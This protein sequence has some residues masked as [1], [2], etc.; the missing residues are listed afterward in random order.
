LAL[1]AYL[2][3]TQALLQNP[4]APSSLYDPAQLTT[5]I[6]TA[7]TW[8]AGESQSIKV[9]GTLAITSGNRGPYAFSSISLAGATGVQGVLNVRMARLTVTGGQAPLSPRSWPWF[10]EYNFS[11]GLAAAQPIEW[12][13]YGEGEN[14]TLYFSPPPNANFTANLDCVCVPNAL[15]VD[16]DPEAIPA[17][18][19]VAVPYFAAYLALLAAQ[20][21]AR[22]QD[23]Q[24]MLQLYELF[25]DRARKFA[26][27]DVVPQQY[28]Q[29]P[30]QPQAQSQSDRAA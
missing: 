23:A 19:T 22:V 11:P 14:G 26:T 28:P 9:I 25:T 18:W 17:L 20:T 6:N 16:A 1:T 2:T 21:G 5:S 8:V 15:A 13:Q 27:P 10:Q 7:R 3:A 30:S 4:A 29:S 12:A 24:R